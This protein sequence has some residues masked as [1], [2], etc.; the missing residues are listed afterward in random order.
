MSNVALI[1]FVC[2]GAFLLRLFN[3]C[4]LYLFIYFVLPYKMVKKAVYEMPPTGRR[5]NKLT[6][7]RNQGCIPKKEV[8]DA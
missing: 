5:D 8:G 7:K 1:R 3:I 4:L 2:S 6:A